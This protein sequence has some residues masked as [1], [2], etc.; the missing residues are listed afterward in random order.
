MEILL[1]I[2]RKFY[3]I[4]IA[5]LGIQQLFY[6]DFRPVFAPDSSWLPGLPIVAALFSFWLIISGFALFF[7]RRGKSFA[8]MLGWVFLVL[9]AG[10][11]VPHLLF[12][13]PYGMIFGAW[14]NAL[15]ELALAGGAFAIAQ[16]YGEDNPKETHPYFTSLS[17]IAPWGKLF[18]SMVMLLFGLT[19]FVYTDF[20][21]K[22][23]PSWIPG[24]YFWTYFSG[25]ALISSGALIILKIRVKE[26]AL[27][28]GIMIF[29]WFMLLHLPRTFA[30]PW[31]NKGNELT[32]ALQ[33]LGFSGIAL[34]ISGLAAQSNITAQNRQA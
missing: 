4:C 23:V 13:N 11:H 16:S 6:L 1:L 27:L 17:S 18:F 9:F 32:S 31:G 10:Y 2:G 21:V 22:L 12:I 28:L 3:A 20:A 15:K 29:L 26:I 5:C 7:E 34:I 24:S 30:D 8:L 14:V 19:H 33:A 25:I